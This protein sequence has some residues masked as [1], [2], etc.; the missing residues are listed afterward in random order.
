MSVNV[1]RILG[2]EDYTVIDAKGHILGRLSSKIAKRLVNGENIVIVNAEKAVIT[3]QRSM[4]LN[5]YIE[6]SERG[7][8]ESGPY[9]PKHPENIFKRTVRGM[10]PWKSRRGREAF[11][12]L[13][14]FIGVPEELKDMQFERIDDA[15]MEKVSKTDRYVTLGEVSKYLGSKVVS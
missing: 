14:V 6:K 4:N 12:G 11:K 7:S 1:R 8:Q 5:K 9:F 3:G 13:K 2:D 15:L 10:L